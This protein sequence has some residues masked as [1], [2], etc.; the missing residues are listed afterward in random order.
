MGGGSIRGGFESAVKRYKWYLEVYDVV[1]SGLY[2]ICLE[3]GLLSPPLDV[4]C[5]LDRVT[6]DRQNSIASL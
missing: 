4:S 6:Y 1:G 3:Y 5:L 2:P